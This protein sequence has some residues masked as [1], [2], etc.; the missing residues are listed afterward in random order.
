MDGEKKLIPIAFPEL[1]GAIP[2]WVQGKDW[3]WYYHT[4]YPHQLDVNWKNPYVFIAYAKIL[5]YLSSLGFNF[6]FDAV[7][8]V[9]KGAYKI[10]NT[11]DPFTH[12]IVAAYKILAQTV[13]PNCSFILEVNEHIDSDIMYFG[14]NDS[15]QANLLYNFQMCELLWASLIEEDTTYLWGKLKEEENIPEFAQWINFLRNHDEI[16]FTSI[17]SALLAKIHKNLFPYGKPFRKEFGLSGRTFSLLQENEERFIMSYFLL[18]SLPGNLLFPYGDEFGK[19]N[20][21]LEELPLE[22]QLDT[23]NIN[24]GFLDKTLM[25][26]EKGKR[27]SNQVKK[28]LNTRLL[29]KKYF[30]TYPKKKSAEKGIFAASYIFDNAEML[31]FCNITNTKKEVPGSFSVFQ[32]IMHINNVQVQEK[33]IVLDAY[34]GIWFK[35]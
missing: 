26:S 5:L 14:T 29:Q 17:N 35:K 30:Q 4:Y 6:R 20:I 8:F 3:Y 10:L 34:S 23:R 31:I 24:R 2:H 25:E 15:P 19:K 12:N 11:H 16:S 9:G 27:I 33:E 18:A 32:E 22:E 13:Y 7:P 1:T 28:I 21:L